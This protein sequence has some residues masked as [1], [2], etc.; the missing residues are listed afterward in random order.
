VSFQ[1]QPVPFVE[2][3][4]QPHAQLSA[5][6]PASYTHNALYSDTGHVQQPAFYPHVSLSA[7]PV[8]QQLLQPVNPPTLEAARSRSPFNDQA[9]YSCV[10][11]SPQPTFK[12]TQ[13]KASIALEPATDWAHRVAG[14]Q[15]L[16]Q[17]NPFQSSKYRNR[18]P[19]AG[20]S[21]P[22]LYRPLPSR[23]GVSNL[24]G[25]PTKPP[26][27]SEQDLA[28]RLVSI[29]GVCFTSSPFNI[30]HRPSNAGFKLKRVSACLDVKNVRKVLP[31]ATLTR[32]TRMTFWSRSRKFEMN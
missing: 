8:H 2:P 23:L 18:A 30:V 12:E 5:S 14:S 6:T 10:I 19:Q 11:P 21:E 13:Q 20:K 15:K 29:L 1:L 7:P 4:W 16:D 26:V 31:G 25:R 3:Q 17:S 22:R 9:A 28:A 24:T 27:G 32:T